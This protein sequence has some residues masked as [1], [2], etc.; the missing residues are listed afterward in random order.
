MTK[1]SIGGKMDDATT[2]KLVLSVILGTLA[3]ITYTLRTI[4]LL[5]KK[6]SKI[7]KHLGISENV[8]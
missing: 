1:N 8:K 6:V 3:A 7:M 4:V 2:L 5:D